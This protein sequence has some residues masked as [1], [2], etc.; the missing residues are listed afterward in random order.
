M[1]SSHR[2]EYREG[3]DAA[4]HFDRT[5]GQILKVSKQEL[6]KREAEYKKTTPKKPSQKRRAK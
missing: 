5:M 1:A 3:P 4:A 2:P 6:T